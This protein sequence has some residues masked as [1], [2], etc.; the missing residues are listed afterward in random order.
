MGRLKL[1]RLSDHDAKD[2]R[3]WVRGTLK[4][5]RVSQDDAV[6][7]PANQQLRRWHDKSPEMSTLTNELLWR[8]RKRGWLRS[9]N[10]KWLKNAL[11]NERPLT[12]RTARELQVRVSVLAWFYSPT[13]GAP[14][15]PSL[16]ASLQRRMDRLEARDLVSIGEEIPVDLYI[17]SDDIPV[18]ASQ[19]ARNVLA[20]QRRGESTH[21]LTRGVARL[22]RYLKQHAQTPSAIGV[23]SKNSAHSM[24]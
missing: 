3:Q 21:R 13:A 6:G 18:L 22:K 10:P 20:P 14:K 23:S 12:I 16:S 9:R 7:V 5:L 15:I 4:A 11:N 2:L 19:L 1:P 24:F 8:H 17:A